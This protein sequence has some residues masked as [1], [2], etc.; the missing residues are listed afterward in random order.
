MG[1][2][3]ATRNPRDGVLPADV[4]LADASA[5][6]ARVEQEF[7]HLAQL[8]LALGQAG[9]LT[10]LEMGPGVGPHV[11]VHRSIG[12]LLVRASQCNGR[13]WFSWGRSSDHVQVL[14]PGAA[15]V[16]RRVVQEAA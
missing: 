6:W 15:D 5:Y 3:R 1:Q 2:H 9:L 13:W 16:I 12:P 7:V 11:L 14:D 10:R 8:T 4:S